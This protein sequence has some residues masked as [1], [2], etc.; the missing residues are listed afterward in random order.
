MGES[1]PD[2]Q[3]LRE[4][5]EHRSETA[6]EAL[7]QR[8]VNLVFATALR[9]VGQAEPAQEVTQNV[10]IALARKAIWL[11]G[12]AALSGWLHKTTLLEARHWWR[13]EFRRQRR[14]QTAAE[15]HTTMKDDDSLLKC[16][17]AELDEA[18][19]QLR[20]SERQALLLRFFQEHTH[21][22][23]GSALGV[24]EDA[25]R[26]RIDKGLEQLTEFFRRRGYA[27][28]AATAAAALQNAALAAP[29]GLSAAAT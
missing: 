13:G 20:E 2:K 1:L 3:L 24:G 7:V 5:I 19:M 17:A 25:A 22:E 23:I 11:T 14:E 27:V 28:P 6:F 12:E 21:R 29:A 9:Q 8:H 18:L 16:M 4:F 10:F 15:L 26:K